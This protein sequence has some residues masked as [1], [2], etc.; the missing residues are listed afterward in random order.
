MVPDETVGP[1]GRIFMPLDIYWHLATGALIDGDI[2]KRLKNYKTTE[3]KATA[4]EIAKMQGPLASVLKD[5]GLPP[6][7]K[8]FWAGK[9]LRSIQ[10]EITQR[11]NPTPRTQWH[12]PD[13]LATVE[14]AGVILKQ[15][16]KQYWGICPFH[17]ETDPSF[18]INIE[19]QKWRCW[20]ACGTWGDSI[21]FVRRMRGDRPSTG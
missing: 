6:V 21:D 4:R 3:L 5:L 19:T 15:K 9:V 2:R 10:D 8:P 11:E 7:E 20:G 12:R 13:L 16:G 17:K 14:K 1:G 18:T